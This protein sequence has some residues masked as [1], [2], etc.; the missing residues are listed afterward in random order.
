MT[1]A[2]ELKRIERATA[3]SERTKDDPI[4]TKVKPTKPNKSVPVAV[5]LL[6]EEADA[7]NE[8][9]VQR[10]VPVSSL[11]RGW[12]LAGLEADEALDEPAGALSFILHRLESD[13]K[14]LR[15]AFQDAMVY[16]TKAE[17]VAA[18]RRMAQEGASQM[19]GPPK[20]KAA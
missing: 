10:G 17:A 19:Y 13:V 8:L 20:S 6:P 3:E 18:A 2:A 12:I 11:L 9:A 16:S 5:R 15:H 4:P 1:T 7:V 14:G